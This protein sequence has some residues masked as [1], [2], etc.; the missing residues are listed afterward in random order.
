MYA[1]VCIRL[2]IAFAVGMLERYQSNLRMDHWRAVKVIRYVQG[3]KDYMLMYR[4]TDNLEVV[5]YLDSDFL[6]ML[7]HRNQYLDTYSCLLVE[8]CHGGVISRP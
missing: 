4:R 6:V 7:I 5:G 2:D 1:Q 8:L 3:T